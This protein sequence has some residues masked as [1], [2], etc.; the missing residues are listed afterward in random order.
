[1]VQTWATMKAM[2]NLVLLF[3][4]ICF[5]GFGSPLESRFTSQTDASHFTCGANQMT[6]FYMKCNNQKEP[7][8]GVVKKR[9]SVNMQKIYKRTPMTKQSNFAVIALRHGC[10]SA[11]LLHIFR[12]PFNK[13]T[14]GGLLLNTVLK[15]INVLAISNWNNSMT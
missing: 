3:I 9:C 8:R 2:Y 6:V 11:N 13:N 1:M 12:T 14:S 4:Y 15:C 10:S 7:S 5:W